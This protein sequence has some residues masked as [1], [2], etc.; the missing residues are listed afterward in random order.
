MVG[1]ELTVGHSYLIGAGRRA[2]RGSGVGRFVGSGLRSRERALPDQ[3]NLHRREL[4]PRLRAPLSAPGIQVAE[5]D[6]LLEVN[7]RPLVP[8]TNLYSLFEGPPD[9]KR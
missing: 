7:G 5:G 2:E 6:Y 8:A 3:T 9:A 1:G 4:E